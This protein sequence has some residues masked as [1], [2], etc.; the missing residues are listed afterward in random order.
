MP[1]D[2]HNSITTKAMGLIS[3]LFN[4]ASSQ[5][6]PFANRSSSNAH[7]MVLPKLTLLSFVLHSFLHY[8]VGDNLQYS[9][10]AS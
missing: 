3:S 8:R 5:D 1:S 2:K 7:I 4:I 10:A 6:V 9:S